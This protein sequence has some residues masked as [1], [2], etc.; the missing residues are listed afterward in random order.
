MDSND[1]GKAAGGIILSSKEDLFDVSKLNDGDYYFLYAVVEDENGKYVKTEGVTF[2]QAN[3]VKNLNKSYSLNF[4]GSED[5]EW[6]EEIKKAAE[7]ETDPAKG[8]KDS[9]T[10]TTKIPQ[11]GTN[12]VIITLVVAGL[13]ISGVVAFIG[14][15]KNRI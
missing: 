13:A 6:S 8:A 14:Y 5:F 11:T 4:F 2:A 15:R 12:E 3:V 7:S 1:G 9:T 10:S